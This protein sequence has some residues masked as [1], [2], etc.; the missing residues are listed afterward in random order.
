MIFNVKNAPY[1]AVGDD[2]TADHG[3]IQ[4]AINDAAGTASDG[5]GGVVYIPKGIYKLEAGLVVPY[6]GVILEGE[7]RES[8]LK[9]YTAPP[10]EVA[11]PLLFSKQVNTRE[12]NLKNVGVRDLTIEFA[13]AGRDD[14]AGLVMNGCVD[15]FCERVTVRG[16]GT[17]M[18]GSRTSGIM[19]EYWSSDGIISG[20][21]VEG[22][23]KPG[24]YLAGARR[25]TVVGCM[26]KNNLCTLTNRE[27]E[28]GGFH[29]AQAREVSFIDCH[30]TECS[31]GF[32][33]VYPGEYGSVPVDSSPAPSQTSF[34]VTFPSATEPVLMENLGFWNP[35]TKRIEELPVL[36]ATLVPP[37]TDPAPPTQTWA[38]TLAA[39]YTPAIAAGAPIFVNYH[40]FRNVRIIGGSAKDNVVTY[41]DPS[42]P[43]Q[44]LTEGYG[45]RVSSA[46]PGAVGR[47]VVISG[48][49]CEGNPSAGI[50]LSAVEDVIVDSCILHDNGAGIKVTDV[51]TPA[52]GALPAIDQTG[53]IMVSGGEIYDNERSGMHLRSVEDVT[54]QGTRFYRTRDTVQQKPILIERIDESRRKTKDLKLRDLEFSGYDA[55]QGDGFSVSTPVIPQSGDDD[56]VEDGVYDLAFFGSPEGNLYAPPGSRYLDRATGNVYRKVHSWKRNDWM[57]SLVTHFRL[58]SSTD[59]TQVSLYSVPLNSVVH[60]SVVAIARSEDGECAVYRR[61]VGAR[62]NPGVV[63]GAEAVGAVQTIGTDGENH[64][65]WDFNLIVESNSVQAQLTGESGKNI[66]WLIRTEIDVYT[67]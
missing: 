33:F 16:N 29:I 46:Q 6:D 35:T 7:G 53:R 58:E 32:N 34:N 9:Y 64:A 60:A 42:A 47:D 41:Q 52:A 15:W 22:V 18:L 10:A 8:V 19:I 12:P 65:S 50:L 21:V 3:A 54:L 17:G 48:L 2:G 55:S 66:N 59:P 27:L 61:A 1:N 45:V 56:A 28:G 38:I 44:Q 36:S 24:F 30:A 37:T 31:V 62:R 23:S 49:I 63:V 20:C 67:V 39:G 57:A 51:A 40:P 25:V 43:N 11:I 13:G 4:A 5:S 14:S 26:S